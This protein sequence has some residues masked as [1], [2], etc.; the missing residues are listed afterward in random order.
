[1][2]C[3]S[4]P[5]QQLRCA[6]TLLA[7]NPRA[8]EAAGFAL[9]LGPT[10]FGTAWA[11]AGRRPTSN[12]VRGERSIMRGRGAGAVGGAGER[13]A[14]QPAKGLKDQRNSWFVSLFSAAVLATGSSP[15][16]AERSIM[17]GRGAGAVGGA[18]ERRAVQPA[19]GLKD[20]R[21]SWFVSLFG[22]AVQPRGHR[23]SMA[24]KDQQ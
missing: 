12:P 11:A 3:D 19:K 7:P 15:N 16:I 4:T 21:N 24:L 2:V 8:R 13:R 6:F 18:G 5:V 20:Q 9:T 23:R 10:R 17:R 22:A 1:M 14:V